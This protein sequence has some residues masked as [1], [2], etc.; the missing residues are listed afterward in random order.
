MSDLIVVGHLGDEDWLVRVFARYY[1]SRCRDFQIM[2]GLRP[3]FTLPVVSKDSRGNN[4]VKTAMRSLTRR[5]YNPLLVVKHTLRRFYANHAAEPP[6]LKHVLACQA[7]PAT[8]QEEAANEANNILSCDRVSLQQ[9]AV[10]SSVLFETELTA[11]QF[12]Y[13]ALPQLSSK[14]MVASVLWHL[15]GSDGV[16]KP[17]WREAVAE[18]LECPEVYAAVEMPFVKQQLLP[19]I[20][21]RKF[22]RVS[23]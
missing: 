8:L 5:G 3:T 10:S 21:Y 6:K 2:Q 16:D 18:Y 23:Q 20:D 1:V 13:L 11:S 17:L 12:L 15:E 4:T 19:L 9:V 22:I 7:D 14:I